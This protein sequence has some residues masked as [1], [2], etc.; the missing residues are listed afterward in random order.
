MGWRVVRAVTVGWM[1]L[2]VVLQIGS[3]DLGFVSEESD[4]GVVPNSQ[5]RMMVNHEEF[6]RHIPK[7]ITT[8]LFV[9]SILMHPWLSTYIYY[10]PT[11]QERSHFQTH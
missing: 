4:E 9:L 7:I 10:L 5:R 3:M 8:R 1:G 2:D 11:S 6:G